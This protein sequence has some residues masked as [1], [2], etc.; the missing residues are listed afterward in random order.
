[1]TYPQIPM[2]DRVITISL[3]STTTY[4]MLEQLIR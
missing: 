2:K 1:M 4:Y 3:C